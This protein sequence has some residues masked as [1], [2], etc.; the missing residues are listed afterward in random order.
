LH[1]ARKSL[2]G[3]RPSPNGWQPAQRAAVGSWFFIVG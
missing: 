1:D 3:Y 2:I